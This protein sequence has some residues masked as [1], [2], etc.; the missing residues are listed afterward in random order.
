MLKSTRRIPC[1]ESLANRKSQVTSD[2]TSSAIADWRIVPTNSCRK[3]TMKK[4]GNTEQSDMPSE[5][6]WPFLLTRVDKTKDPDGVLAEG[7]C[8]NTAAIPRPVHL[9]SW[10][11]TATINHQSQLISTALELNS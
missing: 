6:T 5:Y 8:I 4:K 9:D 11:H 10:Q 1:I 3:V 2:L 7:S